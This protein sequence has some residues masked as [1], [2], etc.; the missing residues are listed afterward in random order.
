M[1]HLGEVG[2]PASNDWCPS[3][4]GKPYPGD[5]Q[6]EHPVMTETGIGTMLPRARGS[7]GMAGSHQKLGE[8]REDSP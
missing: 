7:P 1:G 8:A 4:Q 3:K 6:G 5:T 2:G